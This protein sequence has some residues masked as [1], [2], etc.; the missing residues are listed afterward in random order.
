MVSRRFSLWALLLSLFA[1]GCSAR[2]PSPTSTSPVTPP[3]L[4]SQTPE[5]RS[6]VADAGPP[7]PTRQVLADAFFTACAYVDANGNGQR[8]EEDLPLEGAIF[9][10]GPVGGVTGEDG[11]AIAVAPGG[12][13]VEKY[14]LVA[15]MFPP[16]GSDYVLVVPKEVTIT[17]KGPTHVEFLFSPRAP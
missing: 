2:L 15:T 5:I 9:Q 14:P 10:V 8:D 3:R 13:P 6:P 4:P 12:I 16:R 1:A 7:T 17:A 11:C